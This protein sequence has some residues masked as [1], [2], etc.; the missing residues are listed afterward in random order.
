MIPL[1]KPLQP[2][3]IRVGQTVGGGW[4]VKNATRK[5]VTIY[6][7][8]GHRFGPKVGRPLQFRWD[9]KGYKRQGEYLYRTFI[10]KPEHVAKEESK[11]R[12]QEYHQQSGKGGKATQYAERRR[13]GKR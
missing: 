2:G 13:G 6:L 9:G 11:K 12:T 10:T 4:R 1:T 7:P 5:T 8:G 3:E